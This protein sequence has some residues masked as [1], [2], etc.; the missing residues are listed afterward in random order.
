MQFHRAIASGADLES[1]CRDAAKEL[2]NGLGAGPIDLAIV[3][4]SP[5]YG[6]IVDRLPVLLQEALGARAIA[7]CSGASLVA[8]GQALHGRHGIT[9]LAARLPDT[10]VDVVAI[11]PGDQPNPDAPP[12]AWRRL[13][14]ECHEPRTG[15]I[16]LAEPFHGDARALLA[17][18]DFGF[19]G[20]TKVGGVASGSRHPEGHSLFCGRQTHRTGAVVVALAGAIGIDAVV[21]PGCRAFGRAGRVTKADGNRLLAIDEQ[22]ARRFVQQQ[23]AALPPVDRD[24]AQSSPLLLGLSPDPFTAADDDGF[25]VRNIL[26]VDAEGELVTCQHV[27]V[28]RSVQLLMRDREAGSRNLRARLAAASPSSAAAALLFQCLGRESED[29]AHF[30]AAAPGVPLAGFHCNGEIGPLAG[31]THLHAF[32]AALGLFRR[33]GPA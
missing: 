17:G 3:F 18:L 29:H 22:P 26:G 30:A 32:S 31:D 1:V 7:G 8:D 25:L 13:L 20:I 24:V 21:A 4:A 19:P 27:T 10:R 2:R 9:V 33:R 15:M 16:V 6:A 5:R 11:A 12:D 14:P 28:G 23:L